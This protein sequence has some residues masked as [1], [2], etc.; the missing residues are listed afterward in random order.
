MSVSLEVS[1][2]DARFFAYHGVL[3]QEQLIGNEFI[4]DTSAWVDISQEEPLPQAV[5]DNI[6]DTVSY[7]DL[8]E[9]VERR[10]KSPCRLIEHLAALIIEDAKSRW[11]NINK[12]AVTIKKAAPPIPNS[13]CQASATLIWQKD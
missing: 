13:N 6:N 8:Y 12:I 2:R 7:A 5:N 11:S 10:M 1:L 3:E 9:I 4:V